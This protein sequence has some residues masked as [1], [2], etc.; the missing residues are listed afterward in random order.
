MTATTT[1]DNNEKAAK[2]G[3]AQQFT[4]EET[5]LIDQLHERLP[6][7][8]EDAG[9]QSKE[10]I[11]TTL[12]GVPLVS[13][14]PSSENNS[15]NDGKKDLRVDVILRKFLVARGSS[16]EKAQA[17]LTNTLK[18]RAEFHVDGILDE[19]F[20]QDVFEHV[21][22]VQGTDEDGRPATYNTYGGLNNEKVFGDL[23]RFLRWRVQLQEKG[24][25]K[26]DFVDVSD[27]VQVHD[28]DGV[29]LLSYDKFAKAASKA[30]I[31]IMSDN[32]P[33]TM[34]TKIFANVP[35]WGESIFNLVSRWLSE[36]TRRKFVVVS[37]GNTP[38]VLAQRIGKDNIPDKYRGQE[39]PAKPK[40]AEKPT[41]T[42]PE[43]PTKT[44]E[45]P[46]V[47]EPQPAHIDANEDLLPKPA[48]AAAAA[49]DGKV[50]G[51]SPP[52]PPEPQVTTPPEGQQQTEDVQAKELEDKTAGMRLD[53]QTK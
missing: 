8:I 19:E 1:T 49:D 35:W 37:Q 16:L 39:D 22:F 4:E 48:A 36:D 45:S 50:K 40:E 6:Q 32:Y 13:S 42:V 53:D 14:P 23:D 5:A 29:G 21:G 41:P 46:D 28:Y 47:P 30:T 25:S 12:W 9:K 26:L 11:N 24:M 3:K 51:S 44:A 2:A 17:M 31:Q 52:P 15:N 38:A 18:W 34:H 10:P 20:P 43:E 33:E 27:M 7:V